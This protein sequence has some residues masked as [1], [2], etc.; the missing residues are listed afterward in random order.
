MK[1]LR[2]SLVNLYFLLK[3]GKVENTAFDNKLN[4]LSFVELLKVGDILVIDEPSTSLIQSVVTKTPLFV[5]NS[6]HRLIQEAEN[7]LIKR[8]VVKDD[9]KD[10]IDT[11][12]DY[13]INGVY[14]ADINDTT[15]SYYYS[16]PYGDGNLYERASDFIVQACESK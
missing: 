10:L 6:H 3:N 11:L 2:K 5:L 13:I 7:R 12:K 8:A 1:E 14:P 15:F 4:L 9:P 16:D